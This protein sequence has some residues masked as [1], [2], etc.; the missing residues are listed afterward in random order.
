[1]NIEFFFLARHF[2]S[3]R[4]RGKSEDQKKKSRKSLLIDEIFT[5]LCVGLEI[6]LLFLFISFHS[7]LIF[8]HLIFIHF[9]AHSITKANWSVSH[10]FLPLDLLR[11]RRRAFVSRIH[12]RNSFRVR[13]RLAFFS[14]MKT[15]ANDESGGGNGSGDGGN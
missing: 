14:R 1:M 11:L 5:H 4:R 2:F 6:S 15:A 13:L 12:L 10:I 3:S 9:A 7:P 8:V